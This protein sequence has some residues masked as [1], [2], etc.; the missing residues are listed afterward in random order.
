MGPP[1]QGKLVV[2]FYASGLDPIP[3]E[4]VFEG[5]LLTGSEV[6]AGSL[7]IAVPLVASIPDALPVSILSVQ[8]TIGPSHLTYYRRLHGRTVAFHPEGVSVPTRCPRGGFPFS[9][10]FSFVDGSIATAKSVVPCPP[11]RHG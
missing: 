11:G 1:R 4:L 6:L 2:L 8:A 10:S 9:A 5:E 7:N 3:A